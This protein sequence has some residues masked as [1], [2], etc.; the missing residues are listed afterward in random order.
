MKIYYYDKIETNGNRR[1]I[2]QV[3]ASNDD[4]LTEVDSKFEEY[5]GNKVTERGVVVWWVEINDEINEEG[6]T[7]PLLERE[8]DE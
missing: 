2:G 7:N 3:Y 1:R 4:K 8:H 5:Y 6:A